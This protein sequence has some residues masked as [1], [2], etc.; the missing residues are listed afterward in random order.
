MNANTPQQAITTAQQQASQAN[1]Q[2]TSLQTR[3]TDT[4]AQLTA[5]LQRANTSEAQV[6]SL[7]TQ[8]AQMQVQVASYQQQ[9]AVAD[10]RVGLIGQAVGAATA[11]GSNVA[12]L[13]STSPEGGSAAGM[14]I[15]P[16]TGT[17]YIMVEGLPE[18]GADQTYQA[19]YIAGGS[20]TSAGLLTPG[21]HGLA[22]VGNLDPVAGTDTIALTIEPAGGVDQPTGSPVV[23]GTLP[24]AVALAGTTAIQ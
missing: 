5:A 23:A 22:V 10:D 7:Q 14:A 17:G 11:A 6:T 24:T 8:I 21:P 20:P 3:V 1:A 18:I 15:F 16:A 4:Q 19:W 13:A 9:I 2:L 12:T